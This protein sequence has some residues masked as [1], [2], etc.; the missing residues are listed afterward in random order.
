MRGKKPQEQ[1]YQD[2][3]SLFELVRGRD[4][5]LGLW[6]VICF[7]RNKREKRGWSSST[8]D[9][10]KLTVPLEFLFAFIFDLQQELW[11]TLF[12][13]WCH[14]CK[15]RG[16]KRKRQDIQYVQMGVAPKRSYRVVCTIKNLGQYS[17]IQLKRVEFNSLNFVFLWEIRCLQQTSLAE[18]ITDLY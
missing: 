2:P 16:K 17:E 12:T 3:T 18:L 9:F 10:R 5:N 1:E 11:S 8:H 6:M 7:P 14:W 4:S 13:F 15:E